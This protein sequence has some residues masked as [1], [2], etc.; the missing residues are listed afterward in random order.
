[1]TEPHTLPLMEGETLRTME[2][3]E[4]DVIRHALEVT[5]GNT[6]QAAKALG[7]SRSHFS[8]IV[9]GH[10]GISASVALRLA[11]G[12]GDT[13]EN[14]LSHQIDYELHVARGQ[15]LPISRQV[16]SIKKGGPK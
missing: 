15:F 7:I 9:N 11:L 13:A 10:A 3:I 1:M 8:D 16:R 12:I 4:V 14:W 2:V 5:S 6:V